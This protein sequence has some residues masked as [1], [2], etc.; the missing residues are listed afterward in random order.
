MYVRHFV[1]AAVLLALGAHA[2]AA[3]QEPVA[4][5]PP[6]Q[7]AQPAR[8][9]AAVLGFSVGSMSIETAS[10]DRS[11]VGDRS[12]GLQLDAGALFR[13]HYY[14]GLDVGGQF[15]DDHAEFTQNTTGG[16]QKSTAAVTYFSAVTGVRTGTLRAVPL[17]LA[18]YAGA[19]VTVSRRSI[20]NCIDCQ[21][22]KLD[23]PGGAFVE[24]T[25]MFGRRAVRFRMTDRVY[26]TGDGM[27][28]IV[29]AGI[30]FTPSKR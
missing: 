5:P 17:S 15:L 1:G 30:D 21:V 10:A 23:I 26:L 3:Q 13:R 8:Q 12:F 9:V 20:D 7:P 27:R 28:N 18:L 22:D 29:S 4:S 25:L 19:S 11:Q 2:L 24:P 14:V 16:K 6:A